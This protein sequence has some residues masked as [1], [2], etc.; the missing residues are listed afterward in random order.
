MNAVEI[1]VQEHNAILRL[2]TVIRS[3]CCRILEGGP[4]NIEDFTSMIT[5]ARTYA[6]KHHHGKEEEILFLTMTEKLGQAATTLIRHGMLV[7]HDMGRFFITELEQAL[8][9]YA[10]EPNTENK[11]DII[12][13][14]SGWADLLKRHIEKE[15]TVVYPFAVRSLP[16]EVLNE[17]DR[18]VQ[19]FEEKAEKDGIQQK[20]LQLLE[21]LA[22]KYC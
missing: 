8:K 15:N 18:K 16:F 4:V 2:I 22:L 10:A 9:R 12:M 13:R 19:L 21:T 17:V 5:F 6:D 14:S 11:L 3:A 1:M 20:S 7:E